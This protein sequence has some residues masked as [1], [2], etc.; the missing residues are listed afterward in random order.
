MPRIKLA[1]LPEEGIIELPE[2]PILLA[3]VKGVLTAL[4]STCTHANCNVAFGEIIGN[5]IVCP[6]H[7]SRFDLF[8]GEVKGGPATK[9]LKKHNVRVEGDEVIVE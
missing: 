8:S 6:C 9:P 5:D 1:D 3:R 7:G 2:I 4:E